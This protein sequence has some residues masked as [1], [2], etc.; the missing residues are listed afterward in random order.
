M[1]SVLGQVEIASREWQATMDCMGDMVILADHRGYIQRCNKAFMEFTG[2]PYHQLIRTGWKDLV[3]LEDIGFGISDAMSLE[4]YHKSTARWFVVNFYPFQAAVGDLKPGT[5]IT[6]TDTTKLKQITQELERKNEEIENNRRDL[7][8]AYSELK[9]AQAPMMQHEKM[10][11]IGQLAAGVAHEI[12]N[13]TGFISSNLHTLAEYDEEIRPLIDQWRA[14]S[15]WIL[16]WVI[17]RT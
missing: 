5:V 17:Q 14:R 3:P 6:L 10:A 8:N 4:L 7:E 11:S 12:N 1:N 15:I 13:P 9:A 16:S 2:K